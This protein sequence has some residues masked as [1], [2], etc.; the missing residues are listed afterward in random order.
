MNK[1]ILITEN[2]LFASTVLSPF[3]VTFSIA[4]FF[5]TF[6]FKYHLLEKNKTVNN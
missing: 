2:L 6:H 4:E 1:A 3:F 5:K